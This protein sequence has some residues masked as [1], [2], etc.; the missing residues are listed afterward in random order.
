MVQVLL[1][2]LLSGERARAL[3]SLTRALGSYLSETPLRNSWNFS[4]KNEG[5]SSHPKPILDKDLLLVGL[6]LL[7]NWTHIPF[8]RYGSVNRTCKKQQ[9]TVID[10]H[11]RRLVFHLAYCVVQSV[12]LHFSCG[13][14]EKTPLWAENIR[15]QERKN[16]EKAV[17]NP[18]YSCCITKT[19]VMTQ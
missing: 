14:S 19:G 5:L 6:I 17:Y 2:P 15:S 18:Q 13:Y 11:N 12:I 1:L 3:E 16:E 9:V 7:K 10:I 8:Q 4:A